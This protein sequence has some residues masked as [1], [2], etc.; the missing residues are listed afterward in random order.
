MS[1]ILERAEACMNKRF[2]KDTVAEL[3]PMLLAECKRQQDRITQL[4]LDNRRL[5][6]HELLLEEEV[7]RL[8]TFHRNDMGR[9][10]YLEEQNE[11]LMAHCNDLRN[12]AQTAEMNC[13]GLEA[14]FQ[15]GDE[16]H[17]EAVIGLVQGVLG[18]KTVSDKLSCLLRLQK[19]AA[20]GKPRAWLMTE[21]RIGAI[22]RAV[23]QGML[24]EAKQ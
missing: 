1:D 11:D 22:E 16:R 18:T 2:D 5:H 20:L 15:P 9:I 6:E 17:L 8:E 12:R 14:V 4:Q 21:E 13:I 24:E 10:G 7:K 23:F 3:F 19:A